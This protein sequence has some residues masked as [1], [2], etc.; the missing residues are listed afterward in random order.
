M[1]EDNP[2]VTHAGVIVAGGHDFALIDDR[3]IVD[4][5]ISLYTG[6]EEQVVYDL[7][8]PSDH[9]KIHAIYGDPVNWS[10]WDGVR[11]RRAT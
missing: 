3:Y 6:E 1:V 2:S 7:S 8:K 10:V 9:E 4:L 11:F 5:W